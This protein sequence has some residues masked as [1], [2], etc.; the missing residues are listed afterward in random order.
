MGTKARASQEF[1][2]GVTHVW[3]RAKYLDHPLLLSRVCEAGC[4]VGKKK[5]ELIAVLLRMQV[6]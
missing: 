6:T 2:Q 1:Q 5:L 3:E 4:W